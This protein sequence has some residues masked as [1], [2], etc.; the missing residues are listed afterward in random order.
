MS[1][2]QDE[3]AILVDHIRELQGKIEKDE[4]E[5]NDLKANVSDQQNEIAQLK[6]QLTEFERVLILENEAHELTKKKMTI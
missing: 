1:T 3:N 6:G 2:L 4:K 5:F